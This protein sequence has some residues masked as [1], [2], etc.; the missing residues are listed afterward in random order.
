M[1]VSF[2]LQAQFGHTEI[3]FKVGKIEEGFIWLTGDFFNEE[4]VTL[5]LP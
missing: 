2:L 5:I 3:V 4:N 1:C